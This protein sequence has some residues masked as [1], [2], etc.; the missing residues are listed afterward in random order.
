MA[1]DRQKKAADLKLKNIRKPTKSDKKILEEAGYSESVAD[2][3][4]S[5]MESKGFKELVEDALPDTELLAGHK[6]LLNDRKIDHMIFPKAVTDD[7]INELFE[8][9]G[10]KVRKIKHGETAN[11]VWFWVINAKALKDGLDMAYKLKGSYAAEKKATVQLNLNADIDV[12]P[13]SMEL[14]KEYEGKLF[15]QL[16]K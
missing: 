13:A 8:D 12:D 5:V 4:D 6:K 14:K 7:E 9:I 1:T 15:E 11:H 3:P 16:T 2:H 10:C